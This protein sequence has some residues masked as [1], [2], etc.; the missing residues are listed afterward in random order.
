MGALK[1]DIEQILKNPMLEIEAIRTGMTLKGIL[2]YIDEL[3]FP[4]TE[5]IEALRINRS[6]FYSK[7]KSNEKLSSSETEKFL[8]LLKVFKLS[9]AILGERA[10]AWLLSEVPGLAK[11]RPLDLLDTEVGFRAVEDTLL[12]IKHGIYS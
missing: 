10:E 1:K 5:L 7:K 2:A 8:R 12:R 4:E 9:R 6:N 11:N 3:S